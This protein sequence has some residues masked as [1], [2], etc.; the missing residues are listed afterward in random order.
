M[1][2]DDPRWTALALGEPATPDDVEALGRDAAARE[3]LART[4]SMARLL[5]AM[6]R[7]ERRPRRRVR[8]WLLVAAA[9]MAAVVALW[10]WR[11]DRQSAAEMQATARRRV[12]AV[13]VRSAGGIPGAQINITNECE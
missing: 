1:D 12:P 4:R 10:T 8:P 7:E 11:L 5:T 6:Y 3:A 13:R 2:A 9:A